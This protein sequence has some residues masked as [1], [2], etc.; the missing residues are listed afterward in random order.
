[1]AYAWVEAVAGVQRFE[2]RFLACSRFVKVAHIV[3]GGVFSAALSLE[4]QHALFQGVGVLAL[5]DNVVLMED[6]AK[7]MPIVHPV[8]NGRGQIVG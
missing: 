3:L 1:M 5:G 8:Q 7:K 6:V 2:M 4:S